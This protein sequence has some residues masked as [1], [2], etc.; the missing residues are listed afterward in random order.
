MANF[1][2]SGSDTFPA[3]HVIQVLMST[4]TAS[5]Q[6]SSTSY[7]TT[8]LERTIT[9]SATSSKIIINVS[10]DHD[11]SGGGMAV[12]YA[13][14]RGGSSIFDKVGY[15]HGLYRVISTFAQ[16]YLDSPSTQ[17][18]VNYQLYCKSTG[19]S[20]PYFRYGGTLSTMVVMEVSG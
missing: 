9:P 11:T 18:E 17:S 15:G 8:G 16:S 6:S 7:I 19:G 12:Q 2:T 20:S 14:F 3:G 13:L 4:A 1:T 10:N 5:L